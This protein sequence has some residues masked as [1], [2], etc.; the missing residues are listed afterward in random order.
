MLRV[1]FGKGELIGICVE[2]KSVS[3]A[4]QL[5]E[6]AE[7]VDSDS[8][9]S[10]DLLDLALWMAK[11]YHHYRRH[12][13]YPIPPDIEEENVASSINPDV[14]R[15]IQVIHQQIELPSKKSLYELIG[16]RPGISSEEIS[17]AGFG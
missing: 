7:V 17:A 1:P 10:A 13:I 15:S 14:G 2:T 9:V 12:T 6:I 8:M 4:G 16:Q 5:R 3:D 11:Y